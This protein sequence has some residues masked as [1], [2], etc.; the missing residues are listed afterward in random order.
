VKY[1]KTTCEDW[2]EFEKNKSIYN[3][4]D[5]VYRI[6]RNTSSGC[7]TI[8]IFKSPK[9][10]SDKELATIIDGFY[11]DVIRYGNKLDCYFD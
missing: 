6:D 3:N 1:T 10:L 11:W 5:I 8:T 7:H 4:Y 2:Q 9:K